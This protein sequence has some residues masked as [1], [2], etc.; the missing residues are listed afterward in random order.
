MLACI[1]AAH[2]TILSI[3]Q[4]ISMHD[5]QQSSNHLTKAFQASENRKLRFLEFL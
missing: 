1:V 2:K 5:Y 3:E 4:S